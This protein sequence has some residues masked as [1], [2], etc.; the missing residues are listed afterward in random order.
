MGG[1]LSRAPQSASRC[2]DLVRDGPSWSG[3][4]APA[5][6]VSGTTPAQVPA[7]TSSGSSLGP[8]VR[9][10]TDASASGTAIT[11]V[12]ASS[13]RV[14]ARSVAERPGTTW[15]TIRSSAWSRSAGSST[16]RA[17]P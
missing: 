17:A 16:A 6:T 7:A 9:A 2:L 12:A 1:T 11:A 10:F 14:F 3:S 15:S 4:T 8:P 13:L 5:L